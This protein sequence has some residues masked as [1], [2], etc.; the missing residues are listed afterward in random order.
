MPNSEE[1]SKI[2]QQVILTEMNS[3][4]FYMINSISSSYFKIRSKHIK[5]IITEAINQ[6]KTEKTI[7]KQSEL[8]CELL[9]RFYRK[10]NKLFSYYFS[11]DFPTDLLN[12]FFLFYTDP[13][14]ELIR[15]NL[16]QE[17][18]LHILSQASEALQTSANQSKVQVF[19]KLYED[20]Q[21]RII[22]AVTLYINDEIIPCKSQENIHSSVEKTI[23]LIRLL[24]FRVN[25]EIF[26]SI[27]EE[28]IATCIS[29]LNNSLPQDDFIVAHT[30]LITNLLHLRKEIEFLGA[31]VK[32]YN[33]K[34]L[35]FTD[36]KRLF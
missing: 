25:N 31:T 30:F 5:P 3:E 19:A 24:Q 15:E 7:L 1:I 2:F 12:N 21:E 13:I 28:S 10:E 6:L 26:D 11:K 23:Q 27:T 8:A 9:N 29:A 18:D 22:Y 16:I 33:Y 17:T 32:G 14:Y 36:T 35:D 20:I 34:Q 4:F